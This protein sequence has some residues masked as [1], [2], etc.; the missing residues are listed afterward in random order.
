[1][2]AYVLDGIRFPRPFAILTQPY[3]KRMACFQCR[4][5]LAHACEAGAK[6]GTQISMLPLA[7]QTGRCE[8]RSSSFVTRILTDAKGRP[9][10]VQYFDAHQRGHEQYADLVVVSG[11]ATESAR[12]LLNSANKFHPDGLGNSSG[13][14]GRNINDH[15]SGDVF[16]IFEQEIPHDKG[17]PVLRSPSMTGTIRGAAR[18]LAE[19]TSI[20]TTALCPRNSPAATGKHDGEKRIRI[21]N[22]STSTVTFIWAATARPCRR[23]RTASIS[24]QKCGMPGACP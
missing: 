13:Q 7:M 15:M 3:R 1:M 11:S 9:C 8:L 22:G 6:S 12:L 10:G 4:W 14:V 16:G 5:C 24:I 23:K 17:E 2:P 21:F 18:F 20:T 19:A